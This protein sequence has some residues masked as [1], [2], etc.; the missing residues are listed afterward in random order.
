MFFASSSCFIIATKISLINC[1]NIS[2]L[3]ILRFTNSWCIFYLDMICISFGNKTRAVIMKTFLLKLVSF[4]VM[5][6]NQNNHHEISSFGA[7]QT[8]AH[9]KLRLQRESNHKARALL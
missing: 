5:F 9:S 2:M 3:E 1:D 6:F 7:I 4:T 8:R